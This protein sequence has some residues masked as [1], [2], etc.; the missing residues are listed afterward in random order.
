M[1]KS[2][3]ILAGILLFS[4]GC[5]NENKTP[6]ADDKLSTFVK[7]GDYV[8]YDAGSWEETDN[9]KT[10]LKSIPTKQGEFG[11]IHVGA[12]KNDSTAETCYLEY[13]AD[14]NG[15]RVL[16]VEDDKVTLIHAGTPA[17]YYHGLGD[18]YQSESVTN[19]NNFISTEFVNSEYASSA[20]SAECGDFFEDGTC[21]HASVGDLEDSTMYG[22]GGYYWLAS[23]RVNV[24]LWFWSA[25][26]EFFRGCNDHTLGIRPVV[27][28]KTD[29]LWTGEGDGQ[30]SETA[31]QIKV[32]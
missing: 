12:S 28:L 17:C 32:K 29:V 14:M 7:V 20:R 9:D 22:V 8:A 10:H 24:S 27:E 4:S 25:Y 5:S 13:H 31:Y 21:E 19:L 23:T 15:W 18:G 30:S 3:L 26:D 11:G 1:K 2:A 16:K 6:E